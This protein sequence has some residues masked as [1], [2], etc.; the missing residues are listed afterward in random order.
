[1][2]I[3]IKQSKCPDSRDDLYYGSTENVWREDRMCG[4]ETVVLFSLIYTVP[5]TAFTILYLCKVKIS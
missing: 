4:S 3:K 1:M 2:Y 5:S